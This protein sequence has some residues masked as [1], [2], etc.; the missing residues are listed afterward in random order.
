[1]VVLLMVVSCSDWHSTTGKTSK[2]DSRWNI[3][4]GKSVRKLTVES[5]KGEI[6]NG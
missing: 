4:S 5:E 1:M 2:E 3:L 6:E